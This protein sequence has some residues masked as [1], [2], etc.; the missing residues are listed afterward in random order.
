MSWQAPHKSTKVCLPGPSGKSGCACCAPAGGAA[1]S[2]AAA[3]RARSCVLDMVFSTN[4][5]AKAYHSSFEASRAPSA[6][7]ASFI[8]TILESTCSRP[9]KAPKPQSTP[10]MTFSPPTTRAYCTM[11]SATSSGCSTKFEVESITPGMMDL[12]VGQL[13]VLPHLPFV[14]VAGVRAAKR[15]RLRPSFEHDVDDV[16]QRHVLVVGALGRGPANVHSHAL[17]RGLSYPLGE[18]L[19]VGGDHLAEFFEAQ[20][21]E[22]HVAAE[23]QVRTVELQHQARVH[24]GAVFARHHVGE[25]VEIGFLARVVLVLEVARDLSRRRRGEENVRRS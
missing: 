1:H 24:D 4:G 18:R 10:A 8:H 14:A 22:Y 23:R 15:Q 20:M 6:S 5:R 3:I 2:R 25:R 12:A 13:H 11:R 7:E 16:L 9:A 19:D 21:G 17:G